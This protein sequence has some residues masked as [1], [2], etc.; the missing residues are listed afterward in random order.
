[1]KPAPFDYAAP[2]HLDE[3]LAIL[4]RT[5]NAKVIAG[6]QSLMPM[7]N[8]RL[9]RPDLLVDISR[10]AAL[11]GITGRG[12]GMSISAMTS[13][14]AVHTSPLVKAHFPIISEAM[15]HVAHLAIRNRGTIGGS[16]SHAD[17]AAEWPMLACLLDAKIHLAGPTGTRTLDAQAFFRGAMTTALAPDE[18]LTKV[19]LPALP[20]HTR[21][22][23]DE[24]ALR[25]G[26][27]AIVAAGVLLSVG[28]SPL[29]G[30]KRILDAR[31]ALTGVGEMPVRVRD[32]EALLKGQK[33]IDDQLI[34]R[35]AC[36]VRDGIQP[37]SDLRASADFRREI[38]FS[39]AKRLVKSA[40]EQRSQS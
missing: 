14:H 11:R 19:D 17:P 6:G 24:V 15:G 7:L 27:Y 10:I 2:A 39:L 31:I 18:V 26:D 22:A 12:R 3:A 32:A 13:H 1:M 38:S 33:A 20:R 36:L 21:H 25:T 40:W 30:G 35:A 28:G 4:A 16:I 8:F 5:E 9:V 29:T 34:E 23:F 37:S